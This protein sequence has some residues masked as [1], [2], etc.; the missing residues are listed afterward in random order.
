MW[1]GPS[2]VVGGDALAYREDGLGR[3][4]ARHRLARR[5]AVGAAAGGL[6]VAVGRR[7]ARRAEAE[8]I[9]PWAG[10]SGRRSSRSLRS[11]VSGAG[12][13]PLTRAAVGR[14]AWPRAPLRTPGRRLRA[15]RPADGQTQGP[16]KR[17]RPRVHALHSNRPAV[18]SAPA[19]RDGGRSVVN[20]AVRV[21]LPFSLTESSVVAIIPR[22]TSRPASP[23][24]PW[25]R[26]PAAHD[27]ACTPGVGGSTVSGVIVA[28]DDQRIAAVVRSFGGV[29]WMTRADHRAAP[30]GWPRSSR[31]SRAASSSTSGDEPEMDP[32][33]IDAVV[34]PLLA[35]P[36]LGMA[37]ACR[38][39]RGAESSPARMSSR[40][41]ATR[42]TGP[43]FLAGADSVSPGRGGRA[44]GGAGPR[45]P[46]CLPA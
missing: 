26:L 30:T 4:R 19:R 35:D 40:W 6:D 27:R 36:G 20:F 44:G 8:R 16:G 39:L 18:L 7:R 15:E 42:G 41:C 1:R 24:R 23:P 13:V 45:W 22:A 38:P 32:A 25:P 9:P 3:G 21:S 37:T 31:R 29:S 12:G 17:H 28:T 43:V 46:L 11:W 14:R 34:R 5:R 10:G 2:G 33:V